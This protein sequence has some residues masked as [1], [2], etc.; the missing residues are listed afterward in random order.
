MLEVLLAGYGVVYVLEALEVNKAVDSVL[1]RKAASLVFA[2]LGC[3]VKEIVG[4]TS[5]ER[6]GTAG[7]DVNVVFVFVE[8]HCGRL[9]R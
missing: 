1:S 2:M 7:E 6:S 5:V 3:A 9:A 4:D 8:V